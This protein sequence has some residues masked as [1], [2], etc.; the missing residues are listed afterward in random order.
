M[1]NVTNAFADELMKLAQGPRTTR[2]SMAPRETPRHQ[3]GEAG[4][5][6]PMRGR[7]QRQ[8]LQR[9]AD[10]TV[11]ARAAASTPDWSQ[12]RQ[13]TKTWKPPTK[14]RRIAKELATGRLPGAWLQ[15]VRERR[16]PRMQEGYLGRG[17]TMHAAERAMNLPY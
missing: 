2:V 16:P 7:T 4:W 14:P 12:T 5:E 11:V 15:P 9:R 10:Q 1:D 8:Q 3:P 17:S 13:R 6:A